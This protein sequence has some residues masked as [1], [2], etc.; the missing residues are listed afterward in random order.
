VPGWLATHPAPENRR[1]SID[2]AIAAM[3]QSFPGAIVEQPAYYKKIDDMVFGADPREGYFDGAR[4]LHPGMKFVLDF[5]QGYRTTNQR[6]SVQGVSEAQDA[7]VQLS[8]SGAVTPDAGLQ[9]FLAHEGVNAAGNGLKG[10]HG[11]PTASNAFSV[12]SQ[13][14]TV[15]GIV[16]FVQYDGHLFQLL[17]YSTDAAWS[18]READLRAS[19]SSFNQLTD[20]A[21]LRAQPK[22]LKIVNPAKAL[23]FD[24]FASSFESTVDVATLALINQLET[25]SRLQ[26]GKPYKVVTGGTY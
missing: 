1:Q 2:Q 13:N 21:A 25:S 9:A 20:P 17:G 4:F 18:Q 23:S 8:L 22:Q 16:A 10:V 3:N 26:A 24:S 7:V 15:R 19:L 12:A 11:M 5:P 6:S 14:G